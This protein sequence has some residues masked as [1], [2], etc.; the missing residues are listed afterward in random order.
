MTEI[1]SD[2]TRLVEAMTALNRAKNAI[3]SPAEDALIDVCEHIL[4]LLS[5]GEATAPWQ[6]IASAP[7]DTYVLAWW[8]YW[9]TTPVVAKFA[10][11]RNRWES[12][13]A[14]Q[15]DAADKPTHWMPLPSSPSSPEDQ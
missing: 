7:K 11:G 10:S 9:S 3:T 5:Q 8:P 12:E 2:R 1:P 6:P 13:V 15:E 4:A 14:L